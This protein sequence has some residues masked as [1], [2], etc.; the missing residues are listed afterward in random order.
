MS[1]NY[2]YLVNDED[3]GVLQ[4][5]TKM[6]EHLKAL[7]LKMIEAEAT[8]K[9]AKK[10]YEY[11]ASSVLPME[12]YN[13]GVSELTLV[14]GGKMTYERKFYCQP[15]KNDADRQI[16]ADW[17][18]EHGGDHIIKESAKVDGTQFDKLKAANIPFA[19]ISDINT[20]SLKAFLKDKLG[21]SGGTQQIQLQDIPDCMHFQ[22][23]GFVDIEV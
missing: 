3:R 14:S 7:K 23:V 19:E 13:A 4:N 10:E 21:V 8:A 5:L 18:R 12:M 11:Y 1:D 20:N 9:E 2:D 17:L 22:E 15:N 16:M 6:G